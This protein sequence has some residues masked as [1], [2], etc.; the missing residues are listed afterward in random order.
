MPKDSIGTSRVKHKIISAGFPAVSTIRVPSGRLVNAKTAPLAL[1]STVG[2]DA[3]MI[4]ENLAKLC[5]WVEAAGCEPDCVEA[6]AGVIWR[7]AH[8]QGL[9]AGDDWGWILAQYDAPRLR[10]L[11]AASREPPPSRRGS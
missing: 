10:E 2:Y 5:D 6:A 7:H 9:R 4:I 1:V 11:E 8:G 3:G